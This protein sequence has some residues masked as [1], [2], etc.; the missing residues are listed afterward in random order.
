MSAVNRKISLNGNLI[1]KPYNKVKSLESQEIAT[2]FS[3]TSQKI[4]V[5]PLELLVDTVITLGDNE[6]ITLRKGSKVYFKE[7]VL[8]AQ[9]WPRQVY[10]TSDDKEFV[11][12]S[13]RDVLFVEENNE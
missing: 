10:K 4:G 2:G 11:I 9:K 13:A 12:G 8:Y 1:L 3:V 6:T 5:E 7:E